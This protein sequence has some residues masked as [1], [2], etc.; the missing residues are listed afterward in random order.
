MS[1][2]HWIKNTKIFLKNDP[3]I[4]RIVG[5]VQYITAPIQNKAQANNYVLFK[6]EN[7]LLMAKEYAGGGEV[8]AAISPDVPSLWV[9]LLPQ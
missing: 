3:V 9:I 4:V 1:V 8:Q 7:V 5:F 6:Q 2:D